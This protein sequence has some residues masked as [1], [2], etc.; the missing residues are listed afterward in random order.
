MCTRIFEESP[1]C[2]SAQYHFVEGHCIEVDGQPCQ[3]LPARRFVETL[4]RN[5]SVPALLVAEVPK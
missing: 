3:Y 5:V 2:R 1:G 4:L